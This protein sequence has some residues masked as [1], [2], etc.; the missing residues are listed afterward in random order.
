MAASQGFMRGVLGVCT[1]DE[2]EYHVLL[3]GN[4][5]AK[6]RNGRAFLSYRVPT[7]PNF[8]SFTDGRHQL[9]SKG[10]THHAP[11]GTRL[12][13]QPQAGASSVTLISRS[14]LF[15]PRSSPTRCTF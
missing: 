13:D 3:W 10:S 11:R 15:T 14:L 4:V 8:L 2:L 12:A 9:A 6:A 1:G 5:D 7:G